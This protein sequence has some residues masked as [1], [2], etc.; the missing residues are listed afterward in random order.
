MSQD[1]GDTG[2]EQ[3]DEGQQAE[4]K[5]VNIEGPTATS[6]ADTPLPEGQEG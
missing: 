1:P 6:G 3:P 5:D 4:Q 2:T